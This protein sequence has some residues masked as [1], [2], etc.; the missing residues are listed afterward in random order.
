M[1]AAVVGG[2]ARW[3]G[4]CVVAGLL[5]GSCSSPVDPDDCSAQQVA[6]S[7]TTMTLDPGQRIEAVGTITLLQPGNDCGGAF[8]AAQWFS[9]ATATAQIQSAASNPTSP[10]VRDVQGVATGTTRVRF[11]YDGLAAYINVTVR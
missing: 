4:A 8:A 1:T 3:A 11:S 5:I 7:P 6:V 2:P 9:E 10:L